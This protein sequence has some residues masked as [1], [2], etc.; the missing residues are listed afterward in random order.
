MLSTLSRYRKTSS[1][2]PLVSSPPLTSR[3]AMTKVR[4]SRRPPPPLALMARA[5][6]SRVW[7]SGVKESCIV[8]P[9]TRPA[10]PLPTGAPRGLEEDDVLPL[11]IAPLA[12]PLPEGL[13]DE[14]QV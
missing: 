2:A 5:D 10:P 3:R 1:T 14:S 12:Q 8:I 9:F 4:R 6:W 7:P 11:D 13:G